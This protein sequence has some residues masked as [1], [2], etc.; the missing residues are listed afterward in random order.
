MNLNESGV[1]DAAL[2]WFGELGYEVGPGPHFAP[3][4]PAP[5][6]DSFDWVVLVARLRETTRICAT[7]SRKSMK[8]KLESGLEKRR[9]TRNGGP[10]PSTVGG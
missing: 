1:E 6:R 5:E 10:T 8:G 7:N 9:P 2:E 3:G 4:E